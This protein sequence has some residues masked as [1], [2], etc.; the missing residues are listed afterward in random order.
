MLSDRETEG[1]QTEKPWK[2]VILDIRRN[3]Q[4]LGIG[5]SCQ[6]LESGFGKMG[7]LSEESVLEDTIWAKWRNLEPEISSCT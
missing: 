4:G 6:M 5:Q 1:G 3:R 2:G 7:G